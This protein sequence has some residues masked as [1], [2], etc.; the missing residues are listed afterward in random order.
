MREHNNRIF[1]IAEAGANHN[2]DWETAKNLVRAAVDAKADA[3]KFQTYSS[4]TLYSKY[5]PPFAGYEDIP[6]LIRDIELPR[7]WQK[8]LKLY[9]DDLGIE[10]MSTPFDERAVEELCELGVKRFK[11]AGF[12]S[13]DPRWVKYVASAGL[14]LIISMGTGANYDTMVQIQEWVLGSDVMN[15]PKI[16]LGTFDFSNNPDVTYLHC[17]SAYPTPLE[18]A[19]LGN[20]KHLKRLSENH[21]WLRNTKIGLSDHTEGILVPPLAVSLGAQVIEKHYTLSRTSVGPDHP[22]AIEPDELKQMVSN[23]RDAEKCLG[24]KEGI[25]TESEKV[26]MQ[27]RRSVV[28]AKDIAAG[29]RLSRDNTTTK[30]PCLENSI[31]AIDYFDV[32]GKITSRNIKED[33]IL[34]LEDLNE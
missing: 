27:A 6:K 13:T 11:I 8:D 33:T 32:L 18:D 1:V 26:L 31:P 20:L 12:E 30:R 29:E 25:Y 2:R 22:F 9:C 5:T 17:N 28:A 16:H 4:N 3:V 34:T 14:P 7:S 24:V 15:D 21:K 10:F 23:I 19:N